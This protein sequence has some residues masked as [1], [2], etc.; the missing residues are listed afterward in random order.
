VLQYVG[1]CKQLQVDLDEL[2]R[3]LQSN[4]LSSSSSRTALDL[5]LARSELRDAQRAI[6]E[7]KMAEDIDGDHNTQELLD[8][9]VCVA[10]EKVGVCSAARAYARS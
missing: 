2:E 10:K 9:V 3:K 4:P 5:Q 7:T 1:N 8:L 6:A